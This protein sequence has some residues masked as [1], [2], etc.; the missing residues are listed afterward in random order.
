MIA[1]IGRNGELGY[2]NQLLWHIPSDLRHF[3]QYTTGK[4]VVMGRNTLVSLGRLLP[5]RTNIILTSNNRV[6]G[7]AIHAH[8]VQEVLGIATRYEEIVIIGGE[9]VYRQFMPYCD[10]LV[11]THV[12]GSFVADTYFPQIDPLKW[13]LN[14]TVAGVDNWGYQITEYLPHE[15]I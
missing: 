11:V 8:S 14:T 6:P 7:G 13:R 1:A 3:K 9:S 2:Q 10:T 5:N 15:T 4:P 12:D